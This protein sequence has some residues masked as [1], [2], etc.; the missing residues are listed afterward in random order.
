VCRL[1]MVCG[2]IGVLCCKVSSS[3]SRP[4]AVSAA[5]PW[6]EREGGQWHGTGVENGWLLA[7]WAG[8]VD[9]HKR[10]Q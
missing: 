4:A 6:L 8:C 1:L 2:G 5:E 7:G 10:L 3:V 9:R